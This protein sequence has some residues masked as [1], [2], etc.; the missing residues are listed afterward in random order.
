MQVPIVKRKSTGYLSMLS[1]LIITVTMILAIH[2]GVEQVDGIIEELG[3]KVENDFQWLIPPI[4]V[5]VFIL[6]YKVH[7]N[8][9]GKRRRYIFYS[10]GISGFVC[11]A[12]FHSFWWNGLVALGVMLAILLIGQIYFDRDTNRGQV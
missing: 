7:F 12:L 1:Y 6:L 9:E 10:F 4:V 5:G 11:V 8:T 3:G 2:Y